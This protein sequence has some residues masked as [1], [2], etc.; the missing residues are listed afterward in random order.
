MT[1]LDSTHK[2]FRWFPSRRFDPSFPLA[3]WFAGL[4][5][6]LKS[7]LYLCYVYMLGLDPPPYSPA[8]IVETAYFGA[9][10]IP[11]FLL[12]AAFWNERKWVVLPAI[13]FLLVDTPMLIF[14]VVRL[15]QAG[16]MDSGL[17]RILEFGSLLLNVVAIGWLFGYYSSTRSS[18]AARR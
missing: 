10:L 18:S 17:T 16:Y 3:F 8:V 7:F 15:A 6:Y 12:G 9:T 14:H 11:C 1:S 5:F 2:S 13:L 4:W